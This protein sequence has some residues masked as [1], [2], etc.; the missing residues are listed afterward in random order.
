M[1]HGSAA[2]KVNSFAYFLYDKGTHKSPVYSLPFRK[3]ETGTWLLPMEYEQ[4]LYI[5]MDQR[6]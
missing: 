4:K 5:I 1:S 6:S 3:Q 2:R